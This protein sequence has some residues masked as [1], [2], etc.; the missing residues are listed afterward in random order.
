MKNL[1]R[2]VCIVLLVAPLV[3]AQSFP[4]KANLD[5]Y[6]SE[7]AETVDVTLDSN[8]LNLAKN[9]LSDRDAD[10]REAKE[11]ISQLKSIYVRSYEF[12]KPGMYNAAD[13]EAFRAELKSPEWNRI[14]GV[15][16]KR[17]G[18]NDYVYV[19][20]TGGKMAGLAVIAAEPKEFT[21]VYIDGPID[22]AK[23]SALGGQFGVPHFDAHH[24][25]VDD[26]KGKGDSE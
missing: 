13:I 20:M 23:I 11:I 15:K 7:A 3:H 5:K 2:I 19:R 17:D 4:W 1:L 6:A 14:V 18:E 12:D 9:F 25:K 16:S 24:A 22:L 10:Q 26:H 21:L 8:M